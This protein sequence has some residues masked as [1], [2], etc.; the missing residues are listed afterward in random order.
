MKSLFRFALL[1]VVCLIGGSQAQT[2]VGIGA[3]LSIADIETKC[4][5][6]EV[7]DV[8]KESIKPTAFAG[9][10]GGF[11]GIETGIGYAAYR[12]H[13]VMPERPADVRQ[14]IDAR[15][16]YLSGMHFIPLTTGEMFV[17]AGAAQVKARNHEHGL[18]Q[19]VVNG[20][21]CATGQDQNKTYTQEL[22]PYFQIGWQGE[23][24]RVGLSFIPNVVRS[25]W[26]KS[27]DIYG[28]SA[29]YVWRWK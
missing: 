18:T 16:L 10:R 26:T 1:F 20:A 7:Y 29:A 24:V 27:E 28:V 9:Y 14:A 23:H 22:A 25:V 19:Y 6:C 21:C 5:N 13:A 15:F 11:W 12:G 2:Y 8:H 17:G 4:S 3:S